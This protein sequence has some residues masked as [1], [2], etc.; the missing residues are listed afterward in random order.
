MSTESAYQFRRHLDC[1]HRP[2]RRDPQAAPGSHELLIDE[3]WRIVVSDSAPRLVVNVAKDLQDYLLESMGVSVLLTK[4]ADV[5]AVDAQQPAIVLAT[6][7]QLPGGGELSTPRSYRIQVSTNRVVVCGCGA[8]GV[9]QGSYHLEDLM[10]LREAPILEIQDTTR[11][12]TFSPRMVHSGWGMDAFPDA[13]LNLI[14]H[15]G[16]DSILVF[17]K[18]PDRT[19]MGYQDFNNLVDRAD[20][21][22]LDVYL[23]SYLKSEMHPDDPGAEAYYESTYGELF[24]SCPRAKGVILVGESVE[25]PS[26]DPR[27]TGKSHRTPSVDGLGEG[28][29]S[30]GWWPCHDYPQW[31]NMVKNTVRKHSP[32][33][34]IVFWTYNWG[35]APKEDRLALIRALPTDITLQVTFEMF[36]KVRHED[37]THVCV[38]YTLSYEGPGEYFASEAQVAAERGIRLYTMCNTAGLTWDI[39]VIPYEPMPY[40][41]A[42]R[43]DALLKARD[44]WGLSGL[45]ES[46]HF[47]WWPSVVSELAKAAYWSPRRGVDDTLS[48]IARRDYGDEAAPLV[49]DAWRHW[50]EAIRHY[51]PTNEDQYGPFRIGPTYPLQFGPNLSRQFSVKG[52]KPPEAWYAPNG[53]RI[54]R[55]PYELLDSTLQ[56]PGPC[57]IDA[58]LRLLQTMHDLWA[59]GV[60]SIEQAIDRMPQRK[61]PNGEELLNLGRFILNCIVTTSHVKQWWKLNQRLLSSPRPRT[62]SQTLDEMTALAE[63]EVANVEATI[64]LVERDSRLGWEPSME[65][66]TDVAH[67]RWKRKQV[68]LVI[69]QE[70]PEYR[71]TIAV[72]GDK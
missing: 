42:R 39:G 6:K 44:D 8:R 60:A 71:R 26:R 14:A 66:M 46:H 41:W 4:V 21:F 24:K 67:L 29:P 64:P 72:Q 2:D 50:S 70:I 10:N 34:D 61:R 22:G 17:A 9:G 63:R 48:A 51:P 11:T 69:D 53:A 13:H 1:V 40:Q 12:P 54:V 68:R 23:Y 16:F 57:R 31:V 36:D 59:K 19:T 35:W 45:M 58:E 28:K 18:G 25:F 30:P 62:L 52:L 32:D 47:G 55:T 33:A 65:Y 3:N 7:D 27:T 38:D 5:N 49:L 15:Y 43:H 37:V 20:A 56:S